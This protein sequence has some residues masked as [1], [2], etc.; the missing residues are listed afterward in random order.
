MIQSRART[1]NPYPDPTVVKTDI[2]TLENWVIG[3]RR[4]R[5]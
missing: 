4:R 1:L 5:G 2:E 3:I